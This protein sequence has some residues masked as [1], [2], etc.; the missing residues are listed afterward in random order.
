MDTKDDGHVTETL[1]SS[2]ISPSIPQTIKVKIY[3]QTYNIRGDGNNEYTQQLAAYVDEKMREI[4]SSTLTVDS[5]RVA[6]LA[7]LNLADELHQLRKRH[8]QMDSVLGE[9]SGQCSTLLD[10]FLKKGNDFSTEDLDF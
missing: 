3:N 8:E 1:I 5:L 9:R 4:A 6:I 7:A 10:K 2:P